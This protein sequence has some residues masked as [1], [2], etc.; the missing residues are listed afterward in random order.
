[1]VK[2][3]QRGFTLLEMVVAV[4]IFGLFIATIGILTYEMYFVQKKWPINY[5]SHP[6]VGGVVARVRRDVLDSLFYP[7]EWE[8]FQQDKRVLIIYV[9]GQDGFAKT[10]VY[11]FRK[12]GEVRRLEYNSKAL[13]STWVAHAVPSFRVDDFALDNGQIAVRLVATDPGG[14]LA[15]DQI[16]VPRAHS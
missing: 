6:E 16:F 10:I 7:K 15:I 14:K 2:R 5:M 12:D 8:G 4:A 9:V 13:Q 1:V 11:D 3:R